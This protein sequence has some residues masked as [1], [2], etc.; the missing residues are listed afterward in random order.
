MAAMNKLDY[1]ILAIVAIA[2]LYGLGR[3]ALRMMTSILSIVLGVVVAAAGAA[4]AG[5]IVQ[6]YFGSSPEVSTAAGY[7]ILFLAVV[8]AVELVGRRIIIFAH[9]I[10]LNWIDRLGGLIFGA[11][12]GVVL[13]GVNVLLLS[14]VIASSEPLLRDSQMAPRVIAW[15]QALLAYV[16]P[17]LKSMYEQKRDDLRRYWNPENQNP[18]RTPDGASSGT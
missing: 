4:R 1:L 5:A 15:N 11:A 16:P 9:I 18:A 7:V 2:A 10:N 6:Y 12:L 13:A 14:G 3:G 17:K 8:I